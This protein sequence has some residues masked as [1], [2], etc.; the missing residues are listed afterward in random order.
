MNAT[1]CK[2]ARVALE[3]GVRDLASAANV[4]TQTISRFEA[5]EKLR[6]GT[7][8]R[9]RT[10]LEAAGVELIAE[11]DEGGIGIRLKKQKS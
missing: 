4:S 9:I 7:V 8:D 6:P 2:L 11:S 10:V 1:Q 3:W 5:G